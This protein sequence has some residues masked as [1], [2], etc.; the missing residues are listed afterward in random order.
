[1]RAAAFLFDLDNTLYPAH[2]GVT[3]ALEARMNDFVQ[4]VSGLSY[5]QAIALRRHYFVTYGTTLR[6]L[7]LHHDVDVE[8]YLHAVHD[9]DLPALISP[10]PALV[11]LLQRIT[12]P[13]AIFTNSPREHA[14]R[15]LHAIGLADL[16]LPI[17]DIRMLNFLPKP[18]PDAYHIA[19]Q[20]IACPASGT[21][22]FEDT[23]HN[24]VHA[25]ALGMTTVYI[26]HHADLPVP[27]Y[28][29][30]CFPDIHHA[31]TALLDEKGA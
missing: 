19:L 23:L 2:A 9:F 10:N 30:Y 3:E 14:L 17:I 4:Q 5:P 26:P 24:L 18:H 1:M 29:D 11:A 12:L 13:M 7:Q 8:T 20:T 21:V 16:H 31:I 15:A 28:V 22:F 25:K 27:D 6:G